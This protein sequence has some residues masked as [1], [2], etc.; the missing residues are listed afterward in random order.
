MNR[1]SF[2]HG[3]DASINHNHESLSPLLRPHRFFFSL[4]LFFIKKLHVA[5]GAHA[6]AGHRVDARAKVLDNGARAALDRQDAGHLQDHVLGRRPALCFLNFKKEKKLEKRTTR[7]S[8]RAQTDL[9]L[10]VQLHT[11]TQ[12]T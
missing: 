12:G 4:F 3:K 10:A 7:I 9:Q 1:G 11:C 8:G 6:G 2:N 5:D